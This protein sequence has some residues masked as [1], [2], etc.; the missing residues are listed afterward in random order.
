MFVIG[1]DSAIEEVPKKFY[2]A[3]KLS[4]NIICMQVQKN[5]VLMWIKLD[6][7]RVDAPKQLRHRDMTGIGHY[8]TGDLELSVKS[9]DDLELAKPLLEQ[10]Y[11]RAGE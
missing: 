10:A 8:G 6:P 11:Q 2:I 3:Y 9:L 4:K 1:L 5:K 7:K